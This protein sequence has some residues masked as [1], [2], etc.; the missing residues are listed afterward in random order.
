MK[1]RPHIAP[2][3]ATAEW[4]RCNECDEPVALLAADPSVS[5]VVCRDC[6]ERIGLTSLGFEP[7]KQP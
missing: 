4:R 7:R 2:R 5:V 3:V 6:V 1:P